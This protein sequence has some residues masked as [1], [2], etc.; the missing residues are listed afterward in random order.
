MTKIPIPIQDL[1][2]A[3]L[4]H[5]WGWFE[6]HANQRMTMIRFYLIVEGAV[7]TGFGYVWLRNEY[8]FAALLSAFGILASICFARLDRRVSH[9][10]K[11]GEAALKEQQKQMATALA[12]PDLE[13]CKKADDNLTPEGRR[14]ARYPYTYGENIR[15]LLGSATFAFGVACFASLLAL[16]KT[17]CG[18]AVFSLHS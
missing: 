17:I 10:V 7:A 6:Y 12:Q 8:F 16:A 3:A 5:S 13:I 14:R 9:L 1:S 11:F 2:Q 4:E 15:L 18:G